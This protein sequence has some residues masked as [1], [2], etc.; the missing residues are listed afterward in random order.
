MSLGKRQAHEVAAQPMLESALQL[1]SNAEAGSTSAPGNGL[2]ES[3]KAD[4]CHMRSPWSMDP[5][6]NPL[7]Q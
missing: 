2:Q 4:S 3:R 6:Q 5:K 7:L 1:M